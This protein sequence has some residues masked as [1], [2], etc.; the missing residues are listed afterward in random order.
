M[1]PLVEFSLSL[2]CTAYIHLSNVQILMFSAT[3][4]GE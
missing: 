2:L 3:S 1:I 4:I